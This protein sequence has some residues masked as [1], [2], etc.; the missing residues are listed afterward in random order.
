[1]LTA[2]TSRRA[3]V[4]VLCKADFEEQLVMPDIEGFWAKRSLEELAE[5]QGVGIVE[6]VEVLQDDTIS[7]EE[8]EAFIAALKL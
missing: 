2:A 8:A 5:T 1:M 4:G 7:D 6:S 3:R